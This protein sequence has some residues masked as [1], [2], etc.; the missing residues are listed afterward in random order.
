LGTID[1]VLERGAQRKEIAR[2]GREYAVT[3]ESSWELESK[4]DPMTDRVAVTAISVQKNDFGVRA[5]VKGY[6]GTNEVRGGEVIFTALIV[7]DQ[8]NPTVEIPQTQNGPG[9]IGTSASI[10]INE[11]QPLTEILQPLANFRNELLIASLAKVPQLTKDIQQIPLSDIW[12]IYVQFDTSRQR[13]LIRIPIYDSAIQKMVSSCAGEQSARDQSD[14]KLDS[15]QLIIRPGIADFGFKVGQLWTCLSQAPGGTARII[16][17]S[18]DNSGETVRVQL[19]N[20]WSD[21]HFRIM[22][23]VALLD[24][25]RGS[26]G[27]IAQNWND[28]YAGVLAIIQTCKM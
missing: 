16:R 5:E 26:D 22:G 9:L 28:L 14:P 2:K 13:I 19:A 1:D 18:Y 24:F 12:R 17:R 8:G 21:F 20:G 11:N 3:G 25:A 6:C 27:S 4:K 7:D 23:D 10:R 15:L